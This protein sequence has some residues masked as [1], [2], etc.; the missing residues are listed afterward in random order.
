MNKFEGPD[1]V[2]FKLVKRTLER[3]ARRLNPRFSYVLPCKTLRDFVTH[4]G[5]E[6]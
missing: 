4:I 2:N 3:F 5:T 1:D 6:G